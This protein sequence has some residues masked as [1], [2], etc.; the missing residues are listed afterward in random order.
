MI[1]S[2]AW[3]AIGTC[4][5]TLLSPSESAATVTYTFNDPANISFTGPLHNRV[6]GTYKEQSSEG[7]IV[8][9]FTSSNDLRI[10]PGA[11]FPNA[12]GKFLDQRGTAGVTLDIDFNSLL[13]SAAVAFNLDVSGTNLIRIKVFQN[14]NV[15]PSLTRT[16]T[17]SSGNAYS[18]I[19]A[20]STNNR[21][22][23]FDSIEITTS[24]AS[25]TL[26]L[27]NFQVDAVP[28]IFPT[29]ASGAITVLALGVSMLQRRRWDRA[30]FEGSAE[31]IW[32]N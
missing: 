30:T 22:G 5:L 25:G 15:I 10:T 19:L 23:W 8:A 20:T 16:M 17:S 3:T 29:S 1:R 9:T 12:S 24:G 2:M 31:A 26:S 32:R 11:S 13:D 21:L 14:G 18:G 27:N 7:P 28:E 6:S 4:L